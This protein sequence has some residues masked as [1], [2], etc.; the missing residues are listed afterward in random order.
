MTESPT[1]G[2]KAEL[3]RLDGVDVFYGEAQALDGVTISVGEG[4]IVSL[5]GGNASG[6]STTMKTV[7]GLVRP[8]RGR[9][10]WRGED[11]TGWSTARRVAAGIAS[12]PEARRV[13]PQMSVEDNL[14]VGAWSRGRDKQI[15]ADL[16]EQWQRF[17]RL[18]ERRHQAAGTLSGG[19]QQML[20]FAR[21]CMSRPTLIC[22]DE[23][24]MGLSPR[25]V[26]E[27]LDTIAMLNRELGVAVLMVE[28]MA[29][30]AL[31]IAHRGYV[32]TTGRLSLSG[33]AHDLLH[34]DAVQEAYL[35]GAPAL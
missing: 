21:A 31:S 12:V 34:D 26:D 5:L 29:E 25:L 1:T 16:A 27:V 18:R 22:M 19:E 13:F 35:G 3:L 2:Q 30:L 8:T 7:L 9:V 33:S 32:L 17:P 28:Q 20:A 6:K 11:I 14:L 23:P 10:L 15:Q 24:T 4:E